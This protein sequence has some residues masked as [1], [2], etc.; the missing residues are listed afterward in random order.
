M[1]VKRVT[2]VSNQLLSALPKPDRER[3]IADC[4]TVDLVRGN[5]LHEQDHRIGHVYF[6][7]SSFVSMLIHVDEHSE[8][9]VGMI[10]SEGMCGHEAILGST[11]AP[12]RALVQGAGHAWR[13]EITVFRRQLESSLPVRQLLNR[14]VGILLRQL[15]Q[16]AA[17]TRFHNVEQRLARWLLMTADRAHADSFVVT[18][19]FLSFMLGVRR[20]GVTKAAGALQALDLIHY[21]RGQMDILDRDALVSVACVCYEADLSSYRRGL[22]EKT[23]MT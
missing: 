12:L 2:A 19:E 11:R 14:Y 16:T 4:S 10:G 9:E 21:T 1:P 15:A 17:C 3:F 23:Y 22:S 5:V 8:L 20:A 18:Q 13:M 6:P 7:T